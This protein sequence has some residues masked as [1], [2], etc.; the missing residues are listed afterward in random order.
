MILFPKQKQRHKQREQ[1]YGHQAEK[2]KWD[3]L[4][5]WD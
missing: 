1:I 3:G 4:E 2:G 5:G